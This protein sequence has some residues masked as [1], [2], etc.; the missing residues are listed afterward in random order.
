MP[1]SDREAKDILDQIHS[2]WSDGDLEGTLACYA[3]DLHYVC[4][5]GGIAGG[6]LVITGKDQFRDFLQP[7]LESVKSTST[8]DHFGFRRRVAHAFVS[9]TLTNRATGVKLVGNYTQIAKFRD[10]A[11]SE[12]FEVHDVAR[13][14]A[15]WRLTLSEI[16]PP[17]AAVFKSLGAK[18][19]IDWRE[20]LP[21]TWPRGPGKLL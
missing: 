12:M 5:T 4:D 8:I 1:F 2:A 3:D 7:V 18:K 11:I 6:P 14:A 17:G 15:F 10:G 19:P 16:D 13:M 20:Q 9:C 21:P